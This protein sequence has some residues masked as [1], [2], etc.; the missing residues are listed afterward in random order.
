MTHAQLIGTWQRLFA[1]SAAMT[2]SNHAI[3]IEVR[4]ER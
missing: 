1:E 2:R 4:A 3:A